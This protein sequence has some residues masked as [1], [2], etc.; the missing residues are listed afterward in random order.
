MLGEIVGWN[1]VSYDGSNGRTL[2]YFKDVI[3][4]IYRFH[5]PFQAR[6]S[7]LIVCLP[8]GPVAYKL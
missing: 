4:A 1:A 8:S 5:V 6:L 3:D 7:S 2:T